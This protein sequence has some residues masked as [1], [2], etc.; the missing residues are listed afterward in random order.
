MGDQKKFTKP[1]GDVSLLDFQKR[2]PDEQACWDYLVRMRWGEG[3]PKCSAGCQNGKFDFIRTRKVFECRGCRKQIYATAGTMFHRSRIPLH[4]WFWAI[5]LMATSKKGVSMLYL[6]R[7][8]GIGSYRAVW[9]MGHKI[10]Q[11]MIQRDSLDTLKGTVQV[12]E[13]FV[14]GKQSLEDRR[15]S[16]NNK[17][18]FFIGVEEGGKESP[19]FVSFQELQTVYEEHVLP[20]LE[21]KIKKGSKLKSDGAGAYT[22]AGKSG[23]YDVE[24]VAYSNEPE[25]A[26]EHLKWVNMLT[27][28]LKRFLLSTYHGVFPKYRN[29]YLAEFAYRFNR[30][31]WPHQAFDRLL[32]ACVYAQPIT[33]PV[34]KA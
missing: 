2:F 24:Q 32:Y 31:Y 28:N 5:F 25:K 11:A 14:G 13:I 19:R 22:K 29:S 10:R 33:L 21:K 15:K 16:G 18:P 23:D 30:R 20:A 8:L 17:T 3:G 6:Q 4:K 9:L 7:Q 1:Y 26:K 27:S 34:L 12:D